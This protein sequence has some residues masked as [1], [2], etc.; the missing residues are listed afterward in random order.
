[1]LKS[2]EETIIIDGSLEN[3]QINAELEKIEGIIKSHGAAISDVN[4]W[5]RRKMA[6]PIGKKDQGYYTVITFEASGPSIVEIEHEFE[7]REAI[8]RYLTIVLEEPS[9]E[10]EEQ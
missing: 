8:L 3:E 4:R 10:G 6:Y 7:L 1:M 5:G 9:A 2:Y